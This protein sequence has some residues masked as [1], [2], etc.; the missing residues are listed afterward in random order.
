MNFN[1]YFYFQQW[2]FTESPNGLKRVLDYLA[3]TSGEMNEDYFRLP[4]LKFEVYG[5]N[6]KTILGL[7]R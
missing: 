4:R 1:T 6:T 5:Y 2:K 3:L 7:Y